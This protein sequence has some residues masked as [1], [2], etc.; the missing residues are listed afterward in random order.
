MTFFRRLLDKPRTLSARAWLFQIHLWTGLIA[1]LYALA[2]GITGSILVFREEIVAWESSA[3]SRLQPQPGRPYASPDS[4]LAAAR[5][6][7]GPKAILN[8]TFPETPSDPLIAGAFTPAGPRRYFFNP[9]TAQ[10]LGVHARNGGLLTFLEH[11][12]HNLLLGR[13]GRLWNGIGALAL[14]LLALT[15]I[16]IWWPGRK[17]WKR[18]LL[19][20]PKTSWK[21]INFDLH[22]AIGF[23]AIAGFSLLCITGAWFTWPQFFRASIAR[24]YPLSK[25]QPQPKAVAPPGAHP[26]PFSALLDAAARA[27]PGKT[28]K[29]ASLPPPGPQPVRINLGAPGDGEPFFRTATTVT[30]DPYTAAVL[31]I[32]GPHT[33]TT[34]DRILSW[35]GPLHFGNF[36]G[37]AVKWL[38]FF[39]GLTMPVLF[40]SGFLMW[41]LRVVRRRF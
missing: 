4:W 3:F 34:G 19:I 23:W 36:G 18:R 13:P 2:I 17:L 5:H 8:F 39:L 20:D 21:R 41:W 22:H 35:M 32:E 1:G 7:A 38:Y 29:R 33:K 11:L 6:A 30:L 37:M 40:L 25:P 26:L 27:V 15:G 14:L 28:A 10:L 31:R 24:I 16:V 12:H 9:Y